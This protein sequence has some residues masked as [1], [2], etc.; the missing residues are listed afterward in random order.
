MSSIRGNGA[1]VCTCDAHK[2]REATVELVTVLN[3]IRDELMEKSGFG[4]ADEDS[5]E[6]E[7]AVE[8]SIEEALASE[9]Q[10][11]KGGR[12]GMKGAITSINTGVAGLAMVRVRRGSGPSPSALVRALFERVRAGEVRCTRF[13]VRVV[14]MDITFYPDLDNCHTATDLFI[15]KAFADHLSVEEFTKFKSEQVAKGAKKPA[16]P[17]LDAPATEQEEKEEKEK[18]EE[19]VASSNSNSSKREREEDPTGAVADGGPDNKKAA[20]ATPAAAAATGGDG[21]EIEAKDAKESTERKE[22]KEDE[23]PHQAIVLDFVEKVCPLP[24]TDGDEAVAPKISISV[25]VKRRNHSLLEREEIQGYIYNLCRSFATV[26]Y[27]QPKVSTTIHSLFSCPMRCPL[28]P[29]NHARIS[30][31]YDYSMSTRF[32]FTKQ[33]QSSRN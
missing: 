25:L 24:A 11:A 19:Q 18:K 27:K 10:S 17:A 2:T 1:V 9:L 12:G 23:K 15:Q 31:T 4:N 16:A 7:G 26:D 33:H 5:G 13:L 21:E 32:K 3:D 8:Q 6:D 30:Y 20:L 29:H 22:G 14:P 28:P